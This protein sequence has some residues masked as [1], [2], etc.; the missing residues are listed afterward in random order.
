LLIYRSIVKEQVP[1]IVRIKKSILRRIKPYTLRG[2][3]MFLRF[4]RSIINNKPGL[5]LVGYFSYTSGV[6]EVGRFFTQRIKSSQVPFLIYDIEAPSYKKLDDTNLKEYQHYFTT[7][8]VYSKN[9]FFINADALPYLKLKLPELFIGRYNAAVFFW[10][11]NDYFN[12]PEAFKAINEAIAFTEFIATAVRKAAPSTV[13]VTKLDFPFI[14]NWQINKSP[15]VIRNE[16][17]IDGNEFVFI[18]NFDF[19]SVYERKNPEAILKAF[20]L[21]FSSTDNVKLIMKSIHAEGNSGNFEKFQFAVS[22]MKMKNKITVVNE[23]LSRNE[24]MSM[25]NAADCYISLHRSEGLGLGM[26]EA[27][28]MGKPVIATRYGGNTDFMND[29]NSL[30]VNYELV[31][32]REGAEPY[33]AEWL[34]ADANVKEA[35][36]YMQK[37]YKDRVFSNDLG[38]CAEEYIRNYY[39]QDKFLRNFNIWREC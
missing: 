16:L 2:K 8:T 1:L 26:M 29:E 12:F 33:K 28:S 21:A 7:K 5:N 36:E 30:L 19:H 10:E 11:F 3:R 34:W 23:N 17:G 24:F 20:D 6:A 31:P 14:K 25:I 18:F 15:A 32:V 13:K 9:I 22:K 27:M 39:S 35:A 38:K 37:L 4:Y